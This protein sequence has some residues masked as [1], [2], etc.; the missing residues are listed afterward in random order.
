MAFEQ[1]QAVDFLELALGAQTA[2]GTLDEPSEL[3]LALDRRIEH[4][5]VDEFQDTSHSQ[6]RLLE[7]LTSGWT[8]GDGRTLFL[9][10]DPMQSI[11]R[12][13]DADMTLF[14]R[15]KAE[16]IGNVRLEHLVLTG[17]GLLVVDAKP[18]VGSIFA[19]ERMAEWTVIGKQGRF[20]FPNPLGTLYDRVAATL[21]DLREV[22]GGWRRVAVARELTKLHE[23]VLR[24]T[25]S[26]LLATLAGRD[27]LKGEYV[28]VVGGG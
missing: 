3:L 20:T 24:G 5:L 9:V 10:G 23:E 25:L 27:S 12:F 19:S 18:F 4:L 1:R 14:L 7:L 11:Y 21:V 6:F 17:H 13:R 16:G 15:A 26:E 8:A 2:L 22:L 28:L